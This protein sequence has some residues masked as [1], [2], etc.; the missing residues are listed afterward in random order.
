MRTRGDKRTEDESKPPPLLSLPNELWHL[1]MTAVYQCE[2][3][4]GVTTWE[5]VRQRH[6]TLRHAALAHRILQPYAQEELL[7]I[8]SITSEEQ[9]I[10][11]VELLKGSS[12]LA[13]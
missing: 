7:R 1:I 3:F 8:V 2:A 5:E 6:Q 4:N 11:L 12:R 10:N 13:E 9:L